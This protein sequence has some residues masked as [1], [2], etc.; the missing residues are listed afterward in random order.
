MIGTASLK[1]HT[2]KKTQ[3]EIVERL[4]V[5]EGSVSRNW[6]LQN[7]ITRLGAIICDLNKDG[8]KI[9]GGFEKKNGGKDYVYRIE[10]EQ[11]LRLES[12]YSNGVKVA[13]RIV[14]TV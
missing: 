8:W 6:A 10:G 5:T 11:P 1:S 2:M 3:R 4:L 7:Y 13:E 12:V 14:K 9:E